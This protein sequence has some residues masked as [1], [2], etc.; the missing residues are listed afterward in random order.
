LLAALLIGAIGLLVLGVQPVLYM[1][2]VE[3]GRL[4][5]AG[6]GTLAAAEIAML[7]IGCALGVGA[8]RHL[9]PL[10]LVAAGVALIIFG[11]L[12]SPAVP[13]LLSR[14]IAGA[15][16]GLLVAIAA[17][18]IAQQA[19]VDRAAA[20]FLFLQA[21]TQTGLLQA[22]TALGNPGS[23]EQIQRLLAMLAVVAIPL[24]LGLGRSQHGAAVAAAPQPAQTFPGLLGLATG[25]L[26]VGAI[27]GIWAYLGLWM[28]EAGLAP[29]SVGS[30][31][32]ISLAGQMLGALLAMALSRRGS[33]AGRAFA[34]GG[35]LL[36]ALAGLLMLGAAGR[37]AFALAALFGVAWMF[38]TP[39]LAGFLVEVDPARGALP[40]AA[41]AQ[42]VGA[43][44]VPPLVG[45]AAANRGMDAVLVMFGSLV[46]FSLGLLLLARHL[47]GRRASAGSAP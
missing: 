28:A 42:L 19:D 30:L 39:A 4:D 6:L 11:N 3:H 9:P 21:T 36:V 16:G 26:F 32:A 33:S 40:H 13:L 8:L 24:G 31:L 34:A 18:A 10:L 43:A 2:Y 38:A 1:A 22:L 12:L 17:T 47:A 7:A 15:G 25:G 5:A 37:A 23:A 27:V 46:G 44:L 20:G 29:G 14:A 41:T 45:A 35:L